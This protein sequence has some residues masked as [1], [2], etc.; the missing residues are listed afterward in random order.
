MDIYQETS[1]KIDFS[2]GLEITPIIVFEGVE[3]KSKTFSNKTHQIEDLLGYI[4]Y[5]EN[6]GCDVYL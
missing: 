5:N 4:T 3:L 1:T 6:G 2:K